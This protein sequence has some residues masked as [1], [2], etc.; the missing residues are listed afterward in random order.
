MIIKWQH[1]STVAKPKEGEEMN[2]IWYCYVSLVLRNTR[3]Q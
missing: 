3:E 2:G 1:K